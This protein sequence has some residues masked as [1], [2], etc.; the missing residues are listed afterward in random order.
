MECQSKTPE[1]KKMEKSLPQKAVR[2]R[3]KLPV[4]AKNAQKTM[5][6]RM[7]IL[8]MARIA[9]L[10][11]KNSCPTAEKLLREYEKLEL[12]EG[13]TIRAKYSLRTVYR[14][15]DSLRNDFGCPVK[16]D[17]VNKTYYLDDHNWE[18]NCPAQLS[19]SALLALV[20][21][22][23][24]AEDV[25]P[26]PV[27][28]RVSRAVDEILKGNSPEFLETALIRSLKVFAGAGAVEESPVFSVVFEAWQKHRRLR[29]LYDDQRGGLQEREVDPHVLFLYLHEWRIKAF[30]HLRNAPRTFVINRIRTA[31][32]MPDT[33]KPDRAIIDSVTQDDIVSYAKL[34]GVKVR[35]TGDAPKFAKA[36]RMHSKQKIAKKRDGS[37]LFTV[38]EVPAEVVVPWILSQKG[39]AVPLEPSEL[40]A[41]V[42]KGAQ[43]TLDS[44]PPV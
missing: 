28:G 1:S 15:I 8:R 9:S 11:K 7:Q 17:R 27:R 14:D 21:G 13:K 19:E 22:G 40:V 16:Y 33:F 23:R 44:L 2:G 20:I 29:I 43:A 6:P 25:F 35:L 24:I 30:C 31:H 42:R 12:E 3:K 37:C 5:P 10:L 38:P 41:A 32:M 4:S 18:F 36:S 26:D 39:E 34:H